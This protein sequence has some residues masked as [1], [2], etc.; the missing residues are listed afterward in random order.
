MSGYQVDTY[1]Q[2]ITA[3]ISA[4]AGGMLCLLY[5][6]LR[7]IRYA[8]RPSALAA[9]VQDVAW[10]IAATVVTGLILLVRCKGE[11]RFFALLGIGI[12][13]V[14][15]RFTL[16]VLLMKFGKIIIDAIKRLLRVI[17]NRILA[18]VL[19]GLSSFLSKLL[20]NSKKFVKSVKNLLKHSLLVVYNFLKSWA[21][22]PR[23]KKEQ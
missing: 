9:F 4:A 2:F 5:D 8:R 19:N 3:V 18:P 23:R 16:S 13:F 7:L 11:V 10:W 21:R 12:G 14:C 22:M 15:C 20:K 17:F 1:A 6:L